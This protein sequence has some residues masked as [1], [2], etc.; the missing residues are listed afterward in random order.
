MSGTPSAA[1]RARAGI[2]AWVGAAG[3]GLRRA[4]PYAILAFLAASAVAPVAGAAL[5][6]PAAFEAVLSQLG[7]M[8][9]NF[10][11]DALA[12]AAARMR[13]NGTDDGWRDAIAGELLARL[14]DGDA[15]LRDELTGLLHAIGA[16]EAALLAA[17][18]QTQELIV[19]AFDEL[20]VLAAD[21]RCALDEI[22]R[23]LAVQVEEQRQS[24][25]RILGALAATTALIR[26]L[27]TAARTS[28]P[29]ARAAD[30]SEISPYPGLASFDIGDAP[31]FHGRERLIETLLARLDEQMLGGPPLVVVG[32]SGAGKSSLLKAGLL[33]AVAADGLGEGS[34]AWPWLI[35]TPGAEPRTTLRAAL[36][37]SD[38]AGRRIVLI[39]QFEELFTQCPDPAERAAFV[40]ELA[41][42]PRALLIIAI[43][44]DFYPQCTELPPL[45][46]MLGAGQVVVGPLTGDDL[47]TAIAEPARDVGLTVEPGLVEL[48]G[49]D[50]EPGALPMLAHA[51]RATWERRQG[52]TLT[53]A[54]YEST[55][56][57]RRAVAET[58]NRLYEALDE[59]GRAALRDA[60]LGLVTV[61]DGLAVRRRVARAG[62][63]LTVLAPLIAERLVTAGEDTV[64][65]SHEALLDGWPRLA[66][67]LA[68]ARE[69]IL[70]RQRLT[71]A[72]DDWQTAGEDP[73]ALY[74]GARLA[75][76]RELPAGLPETQRR[77]LAASDEAAE[78]GRLRERRT[79]SRL[80]RLVV[81]LAVA[82]V[83]TIAV[84]GVAVDQRGEARHVN[85]LL[86]SRQYAAESLAEH[87]PDPE[88][89]VADALAAW[90]VAPT[91]EARSAL[92]RAQQATRLGHLG[93]RVGG[94]SVAVSADGRRA[95]VGY[96]GTGEIQ[97]WDLATL[98]PLFPPI[99]HP[100]KNLSGLAFSPD[101]TYLAS[102]AIAQK[103]VAVW[104]MRD[105][106]LVRKLDGWGPVAWLPDSSAVL[107]A[108][109]QND[110]AVGFWDPAGG[111]LRRSLAIPVAPGNTLAVS[112][113]GTY[114]AVSGFR[115]GT[116]LRLADGRVETTVPNAYA[117]AFSS[118]NAVFS[119]L[120]PDVPGRIQVRRPAD[121][122]RAVD[123]TDP[124]GQLPQ[125]APAREF[126]VS[127]DGTLFIG[128]QTVGETL[129][130]TAG[131]PRPSLTGLI[132]PPL[133]L[134]LS[135]DGQILVAVGFADVPTVWRI[136]GYA[137]AHPQVIER[138]A[139][140]RSGERLATGSSDPVIRVWD[141][142]TG[143]LR[144]TIDTGT[145]G[146][147]RGLAYGPDGTLAAAFS[148]SGRILLFDGAN[149]L[150]RTLTLDPAVFPA[151]LAF[152][153][154]GALLAVITNPQTDPPGTSPRED[155]SPAVDV[156]VYE[157]RNYMKRAELRLPGY[158]SMNLAF[159]PDG[160]GLLVTANT[161]ADLDNPTQT[162]SVWRFRVP[163][164][165]LAGSTPVP[166]TTVDEL[167]VSPDSATVAVTAGR[168]VRLLTAGGLTRVR[169]VARQPAPV[170]RVAWSPDGRMIAVGTDTADGSIDLIDPSSDTIVA[171]VQ[172]NGP[173]Q[174]QMR[175]TP[176]S[177][178]LIAGLGD[179]TVGI[180]R[181]DP[182]DA[183]EKLCADAV[184]AARSENR[185]SPELCGR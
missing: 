32:V 6:A 70:L 14:D 163:S 111:A 78:A 8:G 28:A 76:A 67:W 125:P 11:A 35:L 147:P 180:W 166:D 74:R 23:G 105:A 66:G 113:D 90:S 165:E 107:A 141:P 53:V 175:F 57:I 31:F 135:A 27:R 133:D 110:S 46:A 179:W 79:T 40:R 15:G 1:D 89:S 45:A 96:Q 43:R 148:A 118:D 168:A 69:E 41:E 184:P 68:D 136:G 44:A 109:Y 183:I 156:V 159:T 84:G 60:L 123:L 71:Q 88:K 42:A 103:G 154:D 98:Q 51:L 143:T 127:P 182:A 75:A 33:P 155:R 82:L 139:V 160:S 81:G 48:L 161:P 12:R 106:T 73:D 64:E 142:R 167:A 87:Y 92:M 132:G 150:R 115:A 146:P 94:T 97:I 100:T 20:Q 13:V 124:G 162:G 129:R 72:A 112:P 169:D 77:F 2:R 10:T 16:V 63:D 47:R 137:L 17:D 49:R 117:M 38:G 173:Q 101:G 55:G 4:S 80:R 153:P 131:G 99:K 138:L 36:D 128:S 83:L 174:G 18:D 61:V 52:G 119:D 126:A 56:G 39:D 134:A 145:G 172:G 91:T 102:G 34:G 9:G 85:L 130:L 152:S 26:S 65:I 58:A 122:W 140:D 59:P 149:R 114:L 21:T 171:V 185:A 30:A 7:G 157:T 62:A 176:D 144:A 50:Y 19:L 181:L 164:F 86:S 25:G 5:G 108:R 54:A 121:H 170:A 3:S 29:P 95:A 151:N 178:M 24:T 120:G 22:H 158:W 93:S 37:A 177:R 104:D 116:V